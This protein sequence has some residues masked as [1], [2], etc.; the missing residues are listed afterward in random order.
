[1]PVA[2]SEWAEE[3]AC[4]LELPHSCVPPAD[5]LVLVAAFEREEELACLPE[6]PHSCVLVADF[7]AQEAH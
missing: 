1:M 2:A 7:H 3:P 4:L 5:S 6:L